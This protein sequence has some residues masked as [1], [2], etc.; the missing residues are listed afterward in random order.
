[1]PG[2]QNFI[3]KVLD[4]AKCSVGIHKYRISGQDFIKISTGVYKIR[5]REICDLCKTTRH[6]K[7]GEK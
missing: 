7:I 4:G 3:R 6:R 5:N 1:M 2:T